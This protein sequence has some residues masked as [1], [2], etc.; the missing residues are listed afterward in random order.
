MYV[1]GRQQSKEGIMAEIDVV[2]TEMI[3]RKKRSGEPWKRS[4]GAFVCL[5][6]ICKVYNGKASM[7]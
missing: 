4:E 3:A 5:T 7:I 2:E 6:Y 1:V